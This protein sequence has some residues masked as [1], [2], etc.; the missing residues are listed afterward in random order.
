MLAICILVERDQW[1]TTYNQLNVLFTGKWM[2][3]FLVMQRNIDKCVPI[4]E[5]GC[6]G[7]VIGG[8]GVWGERQI[9]NNLNIFLNYNCFFICRKQII[10]ENINYGPELW[11]GT[12]MSRGLIVEINVLT[13]WAPSLFYE[14]TLNICHSWCNFCF[15]HPH[16]TGRHLTYLSSFQTVAAILHQNTDNNRV[17]FFRFPGTIF[18]IH[19]SWRVSTS[20]G[21]LRLESKTLI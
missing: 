4:K 9:K 5:C 12:L 19:Y 13:L 11:F 17:F 6:A 7:G 21:I 18:I 1:I 10:V 15:I 8:K 20:N 2:V 3:P 14:M 16:P